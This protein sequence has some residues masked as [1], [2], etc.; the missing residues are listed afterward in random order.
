M[1]K[2]T[3]IDLPE[4]NNQS[5]GEQPSEIKPAETNTGQSEVT[6]AAEQ[7]A[8]EKSGKKAKEDSKDKIFKANPH[9]DMYYKTSDSTAFFTLNAAQNHARTLENKT[10]KKVIR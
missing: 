2:E 5:P 8:K 6:A 7:M 1:A 3:D 10:V 9:L 4:S